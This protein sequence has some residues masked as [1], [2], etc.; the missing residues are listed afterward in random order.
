MANGKYETNVKDK[1]ILVEGWTRDGLTDEQIAKNLD[2]SSASFYKYKLEH[3]E[4]SEALKKGKEVA[5]YMVEN[6]LFKRALGYQYDEVTEERGEITKVVT[7][8][9]AADTT[10]QIYWLKNRRPEKWR[11]K[12]DS[13]EKL[14]KLIALLSKLNL[15]E[16]DINE[17]VKEVDAG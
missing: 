11:D 4:F 16:E 17:L 2:I 6:A 13:D 8:E 3:S 10:A 14:K 15:S 12:P 7:K 5:D 1:L 9:M